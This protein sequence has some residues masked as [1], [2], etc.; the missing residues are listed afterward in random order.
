MR[1]QIPVVASIF[2]FFSAA[3][4]AAAAPCGLDISKAPDRLVLAL[5]EMQAGNY[6]AFVGALEA[7]GR[8]PS[9][10]SLTLASELESY[11]SEGFEECVVA[12]EEVGPN[13]QSLFV[14]FMDTEEEIER[15]LYVFF[16]V[17]KIGDRWQFIKTQVS[18]NFD[19]A[20]QFVR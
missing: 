16:M 7:E 4:S 2:L 20:Y 6:L 13:S 18:T 12:K 19:D 11:S 15:V 8:T 14:V 5:S 17:V 3:H 1:R 10:E 9:D